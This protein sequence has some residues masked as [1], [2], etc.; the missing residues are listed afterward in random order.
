MLGKFS[1]YLVLSKTAYYWYTIL[2]K[3]SYF[4][5]RVTCPVYRADKAGDRFSVVA[6]SIADLLEV[7]CANLELGCTAKLHRPSLIVHEASCIYAQNIKCPNAESHGCK[8]KV[9]AV[10]C[11]EHLKNT[12]LTKTGGDQ[13]NVGV[14]AR[15]PL[16]FIRPVSTD[17]WCH[18]AFPMEVSG[19]DDHMEVSGT[20]DHMEV[21]GTDD[22]IIL[23]GTISGDY[24]LA[25]FKCLST[26]RSRWY[27]L[28]I[29]L[30]DN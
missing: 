13:V 17:G 11:M 29:E 24:T 30:V 27:K 16:E 4:I 7:E 22:H 3:G 2:M 8:K 21:S 5:F 1:N 28:K 19:T 20:D 26:D 23:V 14:P 18:F 25:S 6:G 9:S 10:N 12:C 15:F